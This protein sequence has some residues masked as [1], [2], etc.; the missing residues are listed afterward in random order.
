M[1]VTQDDCDYVRELVRRDAAIVLD[2]SKGYL[3]EARLA[4]VAR[5]VGL[6]SIAALV[7][8]LKLG[9]PELRS[10]VVEA[11]TTNETS[12]FR[13]AHPFDALASNVLPQLA[14]SRRATRSLRIWSAAC[15]TG[16]E[17]YSIAMTI[18]E[19][20]P[21]LEGWNITIKGTDLSEGV[22][23]QAA[24]GRYTQLEVNRGL[25]TPMLLRHFAR[26]GI[27][28]SINPGLRAMTDFSQMNLI[29]PW[30]AIGRFDVVFIRNVL[31]YFDLP[32]KKMLLDRV[33]SVLAPD[34][35]LFLGAS[36]MLTGVHTGFV[37][38]RDGRAIWHRPA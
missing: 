25:P 8:Q 21:Q 4:P 18:R 5:K 11:M 32:T 2:E 10:T 19:R 13:D 35:Y 12:F 6:E 38:E 7:Q 22:L 28:W 1:T 36:E 17:S 9:A 14:T 29:A 3:I 24:E 27:A 16:Q 34:G 15:S 33:Q 26:D 37:M 30:P 23:A 31:I 20:V